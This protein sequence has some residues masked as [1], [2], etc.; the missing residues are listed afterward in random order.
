MAFRASLRLRRRRVAASLRSESRRAEV[1]RAALRAPVCPLLQYGVVP[2]FVLFG[3]VV[4][5]SVGVRRHLSFNLFGVWIFADWF[6]G[7][8][9]SIYRLWKCS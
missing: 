4:V 3:P 7:S 2:A 8:A 5:P 6:C 1:F 9:G